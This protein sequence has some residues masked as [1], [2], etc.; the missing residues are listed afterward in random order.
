LAAATEG[1]AGHGGDDRL[2]PAGHAVPARD[3]ILEVGLGIGEVLHLLDVGAGREGLLRA[4]DDDRADA[5]I[6]LEAVE[7]RVELADELR[8]EGIE[9]LRPVERDEADLAA[10]LHEDGFIGHGRTPPMWSLKG[11]PKADGPVHMH[12]RKAAAAFSCAHLWQWLHQKVER[13]DWTSRATVPR[14]PGVGQ[15]ACSRS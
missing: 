9:G 8:V 10:R 11:Y 6:L 15:G 4:G 13:P 1:E 12:S 5:R 2:A 3:E 7:R 14:Q